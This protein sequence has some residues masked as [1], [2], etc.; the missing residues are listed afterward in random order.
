MKK[1]LFPLIF[2]CFIFAARVLAQTDNSDF[3]PFPQMEQDLNNTN[4]QTASGDNQQQQNDDQW[5]PAGNQS[6]G[7]QS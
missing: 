5:P 1:F 2:L 7:D 6:N 4:D 3:N